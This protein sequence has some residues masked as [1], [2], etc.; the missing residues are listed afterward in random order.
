MSFLEKSSVRL[1]VLTRKNSKPDNTVNSSSI[2]AR[3]L[4][5]LNTYLYAYKLPPIDITEDEWNIF[6]NELEVLLKSKN[7][8]ICFYR[9]CSE[10]L[11]KTCAKALVNKIEA[12]SIQTL[13]DNLYYIEGGYGNLGLGTEIISSKEI[14]ALTEK[15]KNKTTPSKIITLDFAKP[16]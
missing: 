5:E 4:E 7:A 10:L 3:L 9:V 8:E 16:D 12:I 1:S 14:V 15:L 2:K 6:L 13:I 11:R